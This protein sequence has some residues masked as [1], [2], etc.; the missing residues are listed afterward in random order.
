MLIHIQ[1][2][3]TVVPQNDIMAAYSAPLYMQSDYSTFAAIT[4]PSVCRLYCTYDN[5]KR[6]N[7]QLKTLPT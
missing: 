4:A 3:I 1:A 7:T 6:I 2:E 5:I